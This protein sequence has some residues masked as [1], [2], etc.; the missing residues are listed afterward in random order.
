M[1]KRALVLACV[2]TGWSW[3]GVAAADP[4]PD[5]LPNSYLYSTVAIT[6]NLLADPFPVELE[7]FRTG[8][9]D[10]AMAAGQFPAVGAPAAAGQA[11]A[12]Y[13][14]LGAFA[15]AFGQA[16][17]APFSVPGGYA[18]LA[19]AM[20]TDGFTITGGTGTAFTSTNLSGVVGAS[21]DA[22]M[23]YAVLKSETPFTNLDVLVEA[24]A[25]VILTGELP[26]T[27]EAV[28]STIASAGETFEPLPTGS[29]TYTSGVPVYLAGVLLTYAEQ[30]G[31]ANFLT[32]AQFGITPTGSLATT[33]GFVYAQAVPEPGTWAMMFAGLALLAFVARRRV[34]RA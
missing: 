6:N 32:T 28:H 11:N 26:P 22:I 29:Y 19:G 9:T 30:S 1:S 24:L 31:S 10:T 4:V 21:P 17:P 14:V 3:M 15:Q 34:A 20:F 12:S 5:V 25:Y 7:D 13:G 23:A 33:S 2:I 8:L 16:R 18:A 27:L